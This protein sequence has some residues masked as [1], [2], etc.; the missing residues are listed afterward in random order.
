MSV[1]KVYCYADKKRMLCSVNEGGCFMAAKKISILGI[2]K[3][4]K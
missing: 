1:I 2:D 3:L 4:K